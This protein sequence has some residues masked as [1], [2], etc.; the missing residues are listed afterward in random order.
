M[1]VGDSTWRRQWPRRRRRRGTAEGGARAQ[2]SGPGSAAAS[3]R[4][5]TP[6]GGGRG[7]RGQSSLLEDRVAWKRVARFKG[8][9]AGGG[10]VAIRG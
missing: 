3:D 9:E 10:T 1:F 7:R 4:G 8:E 2:S 6:V 5:T